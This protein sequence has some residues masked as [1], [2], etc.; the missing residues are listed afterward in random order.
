[1]KSNFSIS[2]TKIESSSVL[3]LYSGIGQSGEN[4]SVYRNGRLYPS[5]QER[6][7][8][9][10]LSR[11]VCR[12]DDRASYGRSPSV[13]VVLRSH[14]GHSQPHSARHRFSRRAGLGR[15]PVGVGRVSRRNQSLLAGR[16]FSGDSL[17]DIL[18]VS[19]GGHR[20]S[21]DLPNGTSQH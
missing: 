2:E 6:P 3:D 19:V 17:A 13:E 4:G 8:A 14:A 10:Y 7:M 20:R 21:A 16:R 9:V 18:G 11:A 1:M 15:W 5:A 12:P